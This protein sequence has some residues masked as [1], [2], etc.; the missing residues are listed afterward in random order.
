MERA[1]LIAIVESTGCARECGG[2]WFLCDPAWGETMRADLEAILHQS[3]AQPQQVGRGW[4]CIPSGGTSGRL[5]FA[6]HDEET[7]GAAVRGFCQHF[8][9][10]RVNAVDVLPPHH[11]SGFMARVRSAAT[12]GK[13]VAWTWKALECGECPELPETED[14]W[15]ISLVPTQLQRLLSSVEACAWL[16]R[17]RVVFV[18]GGPAWPGLAEE[19]ARASLPISICYGMTET[20]AMVTALLPSEFALGVRTCGRVLPHARVRIADENTGR[21]V[22]AGETGLV[23]VGGESLFLGYFPAGQRSDF[24]D[25][26]DLGALDETGLAIFG[27]RDAV[28]ITGGKKVFPSDVEDVLRASGLFD[29]VAVI[30]VTDADWGQRVVACHPRQTQPLD[31]QSLNTA[32][33][34]LAAYQRPKQFLEINDWPRN[35]QGKVDREALRRAVDAAAM[36]ND[37]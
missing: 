26:N 29:D 34:S 12:G 13:R 17:M 2:R 30:G 33:T 14:G 21:E 27:R 4:L 36:T 16:Q 19:A 3:D 32:L 28:I 6:M 18:G 22:S 5:K 10:T 20:A 37:Q 11:V 15:V 25:T 7:L 35:A 24:L 9:M 23:H 1:E 8:G 31:I